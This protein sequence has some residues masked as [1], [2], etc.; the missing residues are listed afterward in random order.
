M[1]HRGRSGGRGGL[2]PARVE[3]LPL[4][5]FGVE[6]AFNFDEAN[7]T[8]NAL[9]YDFGSAQKYADNFGGG[10]WTVERT[11]GSVGLAV[12]SHTGGVSRLIKVCFGL[13]MVQGPTSIAASVTGADLG[14]PVSNPGLSWIVQVCCY[15]SLDDLAVERC[16]F[17]VKSRRRIAPEA[18]IFAVA[19]ASNEMAVGDDVQL[20]FDYRMLVRQRGSRL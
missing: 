1:R 10:D 7:I 6:N 3:W 5:D 2:K 12:L 18:Q 16:E 13:G 20:K 14:N 11:I 8:L 15:I 4:N 17:D 9:Q 19:R